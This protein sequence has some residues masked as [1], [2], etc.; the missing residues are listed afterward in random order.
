M[1]CPGCSYIG[2]RLIHICLSRH[3]GLSPTNSCLGAKIE[4]LAVYQSPQNS[5]VSI[6]CLKHSCVGCIY[7]LCPTYGSYVT[8]MAY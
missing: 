7:L 8:A 1:V 3:S 6:L 4:C 2:V 5:S